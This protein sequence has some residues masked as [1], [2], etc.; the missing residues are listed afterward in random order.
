MDN[1]KKIQK[2]R[3]GHTAIVHITCKLNDGRVIDSTR[4]REPL[5]VKIGDGQIIIPELEQALVG[6]K[7][8]ESKMLRI[9]AE[10]TR[11]LYN[12]EILSMTNQQDLIVDVYLINILSPQQT[13]AH[14][15]INAGIAFQ[16]QGSINEAIACFR[17][18]IKLSPELPAAYYILGSLLQRQGQIDEALDLYKKLL[19]MSPYHADTHNIL[20]SAFQEKGEL[21]DAVACYRN[22]IQCDKNS[23]MAYNNL[24]SALRLQGNIDEAVVSYQKAL[25]IK[26]DFTGAMN[27]LGNAL[28]DKGDLGESMSWYRNAIQLTPEFADAHWNL[29]FALLLAGQFEEG[30]K[31]YEWIWKLK[32]PQHKLPQ[33]VWD[34]ADSKG[35]RILLY[36]EQGFG[37]VIQF[38][39]Y[40]PMLADRGAEVILGCQKELKFLLQSIPGV[41]SVVA[42]GEPMPRFDLQCPLPSLPRFFSTTL[43]NIPSLVP[44]LHAD[45]Q[46][47][48]KWRN[49]LQI[50][51]SSLN[52]GLVWAGSPGHLNDR[53]RS[54][55]PDLFLPIARMNGLRLFS[56]QKEIPERWA[57]DSLTELTLIDYTEDIEDFS[58]T[59][60][61]IMNL[62]LIISVDTAVAHLAGALGKL[63]WTLL[64]F[65]PD[66]RWMLNRDDSPWYPTMRLFRQPSPGDWASVISKVYDELE[67]CFTEKTSHNE[68]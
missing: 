50:D 49:R 34:G 35:K 44:Y 20:G 16:N 58:D 32:K 40:V 67:K 37:D 33:P 66:W 27:N 9:P 19:V 12:E 3:D 39:R 5:Q 55:M 62:D 11:K 15:K 61:I 7:P 53:N 63:V 59:A 48:S 68:C 13:V 46:S 52:I 42:F 14:E 22:A 1:E 25:Q 54:C 45:I 8:G 21:D 6:M 36:A 56:L 30:W 23:Y 10:K 57:S 24:G 26:P 43:D 60:G 65:A 29:S 17:D 51:N 47:I 28:R 18:A 31:E 38:V 41:S 2:I 4:G 64:P